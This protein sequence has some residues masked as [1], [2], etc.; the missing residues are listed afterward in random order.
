MELDAHANRKP[1]KDEVE[2]DILARMKTFFSRA[3]SARKPN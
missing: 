1:D 3:F 2:G